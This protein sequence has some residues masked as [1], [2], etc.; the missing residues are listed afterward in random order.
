M[1]ATDSP[2][3]QAEHPDSNLQNTSLNVIDIETAGTDSSNV[4]SRVVT[5]IRNIYISNNCSKIQSVAVVDQV[6]IDSYGNKPLCVDVEAP[7]GAFCANE[8]SDVINSF[9]DEYRIPFSMHVA[10]YKYS[11]IAR[12][13]NLSLETVKSRIYFAHKK[14]KQTL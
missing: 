12:E 10:G 11:E 6:D 3:K 9:P 5:F 4:K 1:K 2:K 8:V 13:M 14:I 7:E